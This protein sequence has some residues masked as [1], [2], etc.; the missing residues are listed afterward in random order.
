MGILNL[1]KLFER[2]FTEEYNK[3]YDVVIVDGSNIVFQT[4]CREIGQLKKSGV[5]IQQWGSI[6][7]DILT[8]ISYILKYAIQDIKERLAKYFTYNPELEMLLV[9]DPIESPK[10]RINDTYSYN[11]NYS[12]LLNTD[13]KEG[14]NI[15]FEIKSEEQETRRARANKTE[16]KENFTNE[17]STLDGLTPEQQQ[18]LIA[19]F[20]Q[21]FTFVE[22]RELL[23][24]STYIIK[25][26]YRQMSEYN[27]KVINAIDE[28]D[29]V[30]KNIAA[31]YSDD[32]QIL[33]L[34][35]DTDY[36]V[37][38]GYNLNVDTCS[39]MSHNVYN[40][41]KCWLSLFKGSSSF[42]YDHIIRLAPLF[43][44]DYTVKESLVSSVNFD[45]ILK[46]YEANITELLEGG[47]TKKITKFIRAINEHARDKFRTNEDGLLSLDS[48]DDML[49]TWNPNYFKKYMLSNIIYTNWQMFNR[50]EEM[51]KPDEYDCLAVFEQFMTSFINDKLK[52]N[53][54]FKLYKWNSDY[55]FNDWDQFFKT[56]EVVEFDCPDMFIDYYYI[57]EYHDD[58]EDFM[59][60][61]PVA[62][63]N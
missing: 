9:L 11:H 6:N 29:L 58:A 14:I 3:H 50:Y 22:T 57:H 2:C 31:Q 40:P 37:L 21:S 56:L 46:L 49:Y 63:N 38:F 55:M 25:E 17:I 4:L 33:V 1:N 44:N 48:L 23:R 19:I 61:E 5:V 10:Y 24:M 26:V 28:A 30:I 45:D 43:G 7:M 53:S 12:D 32:K 42:D 62:T 60:D 36:N 16:T 18:I 41:Y 39:L 51:P 54:T 47:R 15:D 27:F 8:Q 52:S 13:I 59:D 34:S 35:M 20:H